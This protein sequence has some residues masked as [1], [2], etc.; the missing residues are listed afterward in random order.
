MGKKMGLSSNVA[1]FL[2][3]TVLGLSQVPV[4]ILCCNKDSCVVLESGAAS[5]LLCPLG[6]TG[7]SALLECRSISG[8]SCDS[9]LK[10]SLPCLKF[11]SEEWFPLVKFV[12]PKF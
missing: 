4:V 8:A 12:N 11:C 5:L 7:L 9:P 1:C 10:M 3:S 2:I 6:P